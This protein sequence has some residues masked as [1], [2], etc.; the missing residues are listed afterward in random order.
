LSNSGL[1]DYINVI[2]NLKVIA[3]CGCGNCPTVMFGESFKSKPILS[4]PDLI[5]YVGTAPNGTKVGISLMGT[6]SQLTELEAWSCCGG[7]FDSWPEIDTLSASTH[8]KR[9]K[10]GTANSLL[11]SATLHILANYYQPL[12]RALYA[13][14]GL[15]ADSRF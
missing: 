6:D 9:I 8:N 5:K 7:E 1:N 12:M 14:K 15:Y 13:L 11:G 3:R 10:H 4:A 2:P